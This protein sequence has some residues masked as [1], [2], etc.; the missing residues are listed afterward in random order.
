LIELAGSGKH[1]DVRVDPL[2]LHRLIAWVDSCGVYMA[3]KT[4]ARSATP[5]SPASTA[6]RFVPE[7]PPPR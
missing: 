5:T 3:K 4:S 7:S 6:C 1:Y 2:S